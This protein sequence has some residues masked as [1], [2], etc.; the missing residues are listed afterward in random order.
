MGRPELEATGAGN[1][2]DTRRK[3]GDPESEEAAQ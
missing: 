2:R 1:T 3:S